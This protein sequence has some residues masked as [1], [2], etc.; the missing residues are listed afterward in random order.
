[1]IAPIKM[2]LDKL[3]RKVNPRLQ[4]RP[5]EDTVTKGETTPTPLRGWG[6]DMTEPH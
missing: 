2:E 1:M 5:N 3:D 4:T 6:P